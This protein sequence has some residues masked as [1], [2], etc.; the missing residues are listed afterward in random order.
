MLN[1]LFSTL[2]SL[3]RHPVFTS[4]AVLMLGLAIGATVVVFSV[5]EAA[6][7]QPLPFPEPD[8][9]VELSQRTVTSSRTASSRLDVP[10]LRKETS[11][12]EG[13]GVRNLGVF[14]VTF[15]AGG[16]VPEY[17]AILL[18][19]YDYLSVLGVQPILGRSFVLEDALPAAAPEG[20]SA[21]P[22]AP[23]V[24]LAY[25][26]WQRAF[27]GDPKVTERPFSINGSPLSIV[28]VLPRDF[29]VRNE[30]RHRWVSGATADVFGLFSEEYFTYPGSRSGRSLM[31]FGRL[32]RSITYDQATAALEVLSTRLRDEYP[33]YAED[34]MHYQLASMQEA[35]TASYRP[36][37]FALTGGALF[38]LLLVCANLANLMLVRGW[39][40]SG[41][42]AVR[43]AVGGSGARMV[44]QR[45]T[46]SLLLALG[47]GL[48]GLGLAWATIRAL[49]A[50]APANIP[51]LHQLGMDGRVVLVGLAL[52]ILLVV[53]FGLIPAA[54]VGRLELARTLNSE[55]RGAGGR[56]RRRIM[57][58]LVVSELVLSVVLLAGAT[59]MV[60]SLLAMARADNGFEA[61]RA[62]TFDL[63]PYAQEFRG[64]EARAAL[65]R[66]AEERL[67]AIPGVEAVGRSSMVP[68]SGRIWNGTYSP[69]RESVVKRGKMADN[70]VVTDDYF[71]AMGTRLLAGRFFTPAEMTDSTESI[72]VDQ[73]VAG[74]AW[75]GDDPIGKRLF[76]AE[77]ESEGVVVGVVES[78]RMT[79]FGT[80]GREAIFMPEG[81]QWP[82]SAST[83]ALRTALPPEAL[84][85]SVRQALQAIH[86]TLVPYK[87]QKLSD[88]VDLSMA[89]TRLVVVAMFAFAAMAVLVA[90]VGLF[91]V[92]SFA[93][94]TRTMELGIR[95]ALG[96]EKRDIMSMVM[97]QGALLSATGILGGVVGALLL[98]RFMESL[99][100]GVSP[101]DPAVLVATALIVGLISMAACYVPARWACQ[102]DPVG[103]LRPE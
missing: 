21:P 37:L 45:L 59:V 53:L 10:D 32:Q 92:I 81:A 55:G 76:F 38:L 71:R 94:R 49:G 57:N 82:G 22:R 14:D 12:F 100:F 43:S 87:V 93:V 84:I 88:R 69:D 40:R 63:S 2:R 8:R 101:N 102:V 35:L 58:A 17:A 11:V 36:T 90:I 42:D 15:Q 27:G 97:R 68:F 47:G 62:L 98:A 24:V 19:S 39:T 83:F 7:F 89:P 9:L 1:D 3:R 23:A 41:E 48:V 86:P 16:D 66:E 13:V 64:R 72:I 67:S 44:Q 51:I 96:A 78:M 60:R 61:E 54:Q 34:E 30:R 77:G 99:V 95:M 4:L 70:I 25:G 80:A 85:P 79:D 29:S 26:F 6:L 73:E 56:G 52:A 50:I 65:C 46:E 33:N 74:L 28:G 18:V 91:G 5:V 20:G 75:P 31:P 103:A